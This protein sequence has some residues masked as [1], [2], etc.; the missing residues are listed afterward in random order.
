MRYQYVSNQV[1]NTKA[2]FGKI[3]NVSI[4]ILIFLVKQDNS[5]LY[6]SG[7]HSE[8]MTESYIV[9]SAH[10]DFS[11]WQKNTYI[12]ISLRALQEGIFCEHVQSAWKFI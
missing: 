7:S 1:T 2:L 5:V 6:I 4:D 9:H 10:T 12:P 11:S 3:K 8:P